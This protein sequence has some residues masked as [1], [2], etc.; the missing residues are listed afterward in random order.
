[1]TKAHRLKTRKPSG[2]AKGVPLNFMLGCSELSLGNFILARYAEASDVRRELLTTIDRLI[3]Q[4]MLARLGEWF[5]DT[6]RNVI[7]AAVEN[8]FVRSILQSRA[9]RREKR[10]DLPQ[11]PEAATTCTPETFRRTRTVD[12]R[13]RSRRSPWAGSNGRE[14]FSQS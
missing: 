8:P 12:S 10:G 3:E 2:L 5:K 7:K 13:V 1:M 11:T 4:M 14:K 6:D 9:T